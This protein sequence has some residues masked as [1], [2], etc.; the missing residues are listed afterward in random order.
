MSAPGIKIIEPS[1]IMPKPIDIPL[2]YPVLLSIM[3]EG[4]AITKYEI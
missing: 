2:A 1:A 4:I 3:E